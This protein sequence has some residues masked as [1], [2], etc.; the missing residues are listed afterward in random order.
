MSAADGRR[1]WM[2]YTACLWALCFA[3]PH[4]WWALGWPLGFP[5]GPANYQRWMSSGWRYAYDVVVV[6][7]GMLGAGVALTLA[8]PGITQF[9]RGASALAWFAA[10]LLAIRGVAGLVADG[11]SDLVWWP[12]FLA[13]GLLFG[14]A[15]RLSRVQLETSTARSDVVSGPPFRR[16]S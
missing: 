16:P 5:G 3:A 8:Q 13:G 12:A 7:L 9:R 11:A 15:A 1:R 10:A 4:A 6:V 2:C 14:G